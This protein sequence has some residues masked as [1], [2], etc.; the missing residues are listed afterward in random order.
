MNKPAAKITSICAPVISI[1]IHSS[2]SNDK[3]GQFGL[4]HQI[5]GKKV[6]KPD[7][8]QA[9]STGNHSMQRSKNRW[10]PYAQKPFSTM[11]ST[12]A[13]YADTL[14]PRQLLGLKTN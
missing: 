12:T 8:N 1:R 13:S 7:K 10:L 11:R 2:V 6:A 3:I 14:N 9:N 5:W 4:K